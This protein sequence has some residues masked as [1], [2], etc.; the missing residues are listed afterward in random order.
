M[1]KL[2]GEYSP[3]II[4]EDK[5]GRKLS[6]DVDG[7]REKISF[8]TFDDRKDI[9]EIVMLNGK[10]NGKRILYSENGNKKIITTYLNYDFDVDNLELNV[11]EIRKKELGNLMLG[12]IREG[13]LEKKHLERISGEILIRRQLLE[14]AADNYSKIL[15]YLEERQN[16]FIRRT[17]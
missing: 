12:H 5:G 1:I 16:N 10:D 8:Y 9:V 3:L 2:S 17:I 11:W 7:E 15:G 4:R 13:E 6:C 14:H